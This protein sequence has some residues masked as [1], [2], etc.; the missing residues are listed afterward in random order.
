MSLERI[1]K[2]EEGERGEVRR[3]GL[4]EEELGAEA[5]EGC[6]GESEGG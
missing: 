1:C 4:K 2:W 5:E 3:E 6:F